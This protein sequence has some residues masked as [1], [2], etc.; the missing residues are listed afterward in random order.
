MMRGT[1]QEIDRSSGTGEAGS[2]VSTR[3]SCT[4]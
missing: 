4:G 3:A 1:A 2:V